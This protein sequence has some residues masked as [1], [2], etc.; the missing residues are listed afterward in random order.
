MISGQNAE[1]LH[2]NLITFS[3]LEGKSG[4]KKQEQ[5]LYQH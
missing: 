2:V 3:P 4:G 5:D 1:C